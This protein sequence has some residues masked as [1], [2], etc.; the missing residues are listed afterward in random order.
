MSV[1]NM[2]CFSN[3]FM[4]YIDVVLF[5]FYD[6]YLLVGCPGGNFILRDNIY[7]LI[8]CMVVHFMMYTVL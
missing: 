7:L 2:E 3:H 4:I 8:E 1:L 5:F 6:G